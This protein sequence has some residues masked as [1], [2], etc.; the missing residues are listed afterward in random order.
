MHVWSYGNNTCVCLSVLICAVVSVGLS[1]AVGWFGKYIGSGMA[2]HDGKW[3][4]FSSE[5]RYGGALVSWNC[6]T[7]C[8]R[9][10]AVGLQPFEV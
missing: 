1:V 6:W 10:E 2:A 3:P 7:E 5:S 4:F 9:I 8:F